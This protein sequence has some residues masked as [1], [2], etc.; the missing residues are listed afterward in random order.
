MCSLP[1]S[2]LLQALDLSE[3]LFTIPDLTTRLIKHHLPRS[4]TTDKGHMQQHRA[5]TASTRNI[6]S[7]IIAAHAKVDCMIP[8]Q[9][10]CDM[11]DMICFAALA[12]AIMSTMYTN[13]TGAFPARSF[14]SM[15]WCLFLTSTTLMQSLSR[16]CCLA[17]TLPWYKHS[18]KSSPY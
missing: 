14:K 16:P 13:I 9:E 15:N 4:T 11:Q 5:N 12:N 10:I 3:E 7:D 8:P 6:Q 17:P 1:A 2:T 18:P